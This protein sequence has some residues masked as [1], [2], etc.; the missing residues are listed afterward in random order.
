MEQPSLFAE[1]QPKPAKH[2]A[3]A[4]P[5]PGAAQ[6]RGLDGWLINECAIC[7]SCTPEGPAKARGPNDTIPGCGRCAHDPDW[8]YV[9]LGAYPERCK[10]EPSRY[11]II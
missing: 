5:V 6:A 7:K 2:E 1:D 3:V 11:E 4:V 10:F 8:I 9:G